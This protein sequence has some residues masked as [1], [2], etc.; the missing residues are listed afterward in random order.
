MIII[1]L[2][3]I[4]LLDVMDGFHVYRRVL[5]VIDVYVMFDLD[6][7]DACHWSWV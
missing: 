6:V 4:S 7:S 3:N 2:S 5:C 1:H